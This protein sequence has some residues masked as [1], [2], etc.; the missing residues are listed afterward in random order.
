MKRNLELLVFTATAA[1]AG[2]TAATAVAGD[3]LI[4]K[5]GKAARCLAMWADMQ[6]AG[7]VQLIRQNSGHDTTRDLRFE[8]PASQI[9]LMTALGLAFPLA[10]QET[11]SPTIF[12]GG[13]AGD[14]E[15]VVM[16]NEYE[17]LAG[18]G[19]Q[20]LI[21]W[22]ALI[23]RMEN[24]VTVDATI[25]AA[26]G[27]AFATSEETI[28][29]DS[30]LLKANTDYAWIGYRVR[31]EAAAVYLKGPDTANVRVGGP[32][33]DLQGEVTSQWFAMLSR[34]YARPCIPVF[35]TGNKGSTVIGV[36]ADENAGNINVSLLLAK[37]K[38]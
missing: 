37:L 30:D 17:E 21:D 2:G 11:L 13:V 25:A 38:S 27:P 12:G 3:S 19:E 10:A 29:A 8:I 9:E 33:N 32:G 16:L 14:V 24:L 35:N 5:N 4:I 7:A 22:D 31:Q 34:A 1:A 18:L 36:H 28:F 15:T 6:T 23:K 26:V 20:R